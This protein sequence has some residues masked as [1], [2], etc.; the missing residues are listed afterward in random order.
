MFLFGGTEILCKFG[1]SDRKSSIHIVAQI[2]SYTLSCTNSMKIGGQALLQIRLKK[3]VSTKI[4][5][6]TKK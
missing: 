2:F 1:G 3:H 6:K 5:K 4:T